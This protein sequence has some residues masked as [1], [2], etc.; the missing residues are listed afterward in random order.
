MEMAERFAAKAHEGQDYRYEPYIEHP[1]RVAAAVSERARV[2]AWLHD[3]LEDAGVLPVWLDRTDR[4]AIHLLTRTKTG[5]PEE[6]GRYIE[7]IASA[8]GESG[9]LARE[10]KIADLRD[11][12]AHDPPD[13]LRRRYESALAVLNPRATPPEKCRPG[14]VGT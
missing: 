9:D 13:S 6:Y 12:L 1:R 8:T 10:V 3:C 14:E 2:V 7:R 11:H 4:A 5:E